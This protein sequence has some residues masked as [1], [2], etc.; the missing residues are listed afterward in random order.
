[1]GGILSL[2]CH[3]RGAYVAEELR[4]R[5]RRILRECPQMDSAFATLAR[6]SHPPECV[7]SDARNPSKVSAAEIARLVLAMRDRNVKSGLDWRRLKL[8]AE[9]FL[10][11]AGQASVPQE[12]VNCL[13]RTGECIWLE[14][15]D[16]N[17]YE[18]CEPT[19][20]RDHG[21]CP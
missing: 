8:L 6:S 18:K 9:H 15:P 21:L 10:T 13:A 14:R 5:V 7:Q 2:C 16:S 1:M 12:E 20:G 19:G 4:S 17:T 11:I 3:L